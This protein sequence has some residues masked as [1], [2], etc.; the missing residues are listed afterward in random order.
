MVGDL[1]LRKSRAGK[2]GEAQPDAVM[3]RVLTM[4]LRPLSRSYDRDICSGNQD[5]N[6]IFL[7][8]F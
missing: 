7:E 1:R 5:L 3:G 4:S 8:I 2:A 6:T